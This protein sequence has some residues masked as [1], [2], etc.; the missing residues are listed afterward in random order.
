MPWKSNTELWDVIGALIVSIVSGIISITRRIANGQSASIFW[1]I[2]EFLT[3]ILCGY[4]M[5]DAYPHIE[6]SLPD[7]ATLPLTVA[8]AAHAGGRLFQEIENEFFR[9]YTN[10]FDRRKP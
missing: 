1:V 5:Y 3:A 10:L 6:T 9:R 2:S 8:F 7:W 4:L